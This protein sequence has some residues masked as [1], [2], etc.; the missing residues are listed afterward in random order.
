MPRSRIL[1]ELVTRVQ[2]P[3]VGV[4]A[5]LWCAVILVWLI[6]PV[7]GQPVISFSPD[8]ADVAPGDTVDIDVVIDASATG[9]HCYAVTFTVNKSFVQLVDIL[10]GPLFPNTGEQTFFSW[11]DEG[12]SLHF[13]NC[14]LGF[15]TYAD[16]PG[17]LATV[18]L[19]AH[20]S[21]AITE[22]SFTTVEIYDTLL[23]SMPVTGTNGHLVIQYDNPSFD[24][25]PNAFWPCGVE[26]TM[27]LQTSPNVRDI[28]GAF[29]RIGY[30]ADHIQPLNVIKGPTLTPPGDYFV[31][32]TIYE[33]SIRISF[34]DLEDTYNGPGDMIGIVYLTDL[35]TI[36]GSAGSHLRIDSSVVRDTGNHTLP[37]LTSNALVLIDCAPPEVDV[38]SPLPGD[39]TPTPP[40]CT[41]WI[42]D[43][44][45]GLV[46]ASY[47]VDACSGE[48]SEFWSHDHPGVE[49]TF[50]WTP[51]AMD[52]GDHNV[53]FRTVDNFGNVTADDC[54]PGF[55]YTISWAGG[56]CIG[57]R[58]NVDGSVDEE[59]SLGDLTVLIDHLFISFEDLPCWQEANVD[60]SIPEGPSSVSLGDLTVLIDHLF[61]S[62][63][64]MPPCP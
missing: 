36:P 28:K 43:G 57:F 37:H 61:I 55:T 33:D 56:C 41:L 13:E 2:Q 59:P 58:G 44:G 4:R 14:L 34:A 51:P 7:Y 12:D 16:G 54:M 22:L 47:R 17:V 53:Y 50:T 38:L 1:E 23:A 3:G 49:T 40:E 21:L 52:E 62:F 27:W 18:R 60:E 9:I 35:A 25:A 15:G 31:H 63:A 64:T 6:S 26:D 20:Q 19:A 8:S 39:T 42:H 5:A 11:D 46:N 48:W 24:L 45:A 32:G 30:E 29:F 10:E